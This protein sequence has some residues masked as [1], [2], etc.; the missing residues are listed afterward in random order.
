M[1]RDSGKNTMFFFSLNFILLNIGRIPS[2]KILSEIKSIVSYIS[3]A[4]K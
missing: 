4:F 2:P 1:S 3:I